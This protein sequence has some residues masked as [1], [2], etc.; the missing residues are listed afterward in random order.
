MRPTQA[1]AIQG[2]ALDRFLRQ[3]GYCMQQQSSERLHAEPLSPELSPSP[4]LAP[5]GLGKNPLVL[6]LTRG[7]AC[8]DQGQQHYE[9]QQRERSIAALGFHINLNPV[10]A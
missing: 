5:A 10:P 9:K 1:L 8:V 2:P 6:A 4:R 7:E 3:H